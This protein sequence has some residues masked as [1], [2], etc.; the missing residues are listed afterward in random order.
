MLR[1]ELPALIGRLNAVS[2]QGL[3]QAAVLCAE[4][5]APEV[6]AGHLLLALIDQPLC[7]LRCLLEGQ[8]VDLHELRARLAEETRPP[9]DLA[10]TTPSFSPLLVE[11]LQDAWLLATTEFSYD[12]LRSGMIFTALLHNTGRYVGPRSAALLAEINREGLRRGFE[13]LA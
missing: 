1:V 12:S 6:T 13:R 3:E 2:R 5:Q 9:R 8:G 7:D 4:Q 10:V 11:L